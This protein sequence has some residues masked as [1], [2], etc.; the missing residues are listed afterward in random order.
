M[1]Y[2]WRPPMDLKS[3]LQKKAKD[4]GIPLSNLL[5]L[6]CREYLTKDKTKVIEKG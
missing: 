2:V 1:A 4:M 6:I 5:I 3:Q